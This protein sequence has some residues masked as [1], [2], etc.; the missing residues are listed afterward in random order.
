[1]DED[2]RSLSKR[3]RRWLNNLAVTD[4][5]LKEY[6]VQIT[7][8]KIQQHDQQSKHCGQQSASKHVRARAAYSE[9]QHNP[10]RS[11]RSVQQSSPS[12]EVSVRASCS[13]PRAEED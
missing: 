1:M 10:D 12:D 11:R 4:D 6:R 2:L 3:E 5:F 7:I 13:S 8:V 9:Q